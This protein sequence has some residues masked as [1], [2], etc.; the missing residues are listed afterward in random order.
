MSKEITNAR[1]VMREAFEKDPDFK[2]T[3]IDNVDCALLDY[4]DKYSMSLFS[5]FNQKE[6]REKL[7]E[8]IVDL[9]FAE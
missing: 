6:A 8:R 9:I 4:E 7:A 3:Y 5:L 1:R 2:R